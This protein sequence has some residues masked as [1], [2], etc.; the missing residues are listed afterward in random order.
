MDDR[1]GWF[2]SADWSPEARELFEAKLK[3]ARASKPQYL[4]IKA[5]ALLTSGDVTRIEAAIELLSRYIADHSDQTWELPLVL[6]HLADAH[7]ALGNRDEAEAFYRASTA[8]QEDR[9]ST[10]A[11]LKLAEFL[12]TKADASSLNEAEQVLDRIANGRDLRL[13]FNSD[14][15]RYHLAMARIAIRTDRAQLAVEHAQ[16]ALAR[17]ANRKPDFPRHPTLGLVRTDDA[18]R[19]ELTGI[20]ELGR[21]YRTDS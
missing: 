6:H 8:L 16:N 7:S 14:W 13:L 5:L 17:A 19:D 9:G 12:I 4:R 3:R 2:R 10:G 1:D 11:E 15:F 21:R 18:T 20:A